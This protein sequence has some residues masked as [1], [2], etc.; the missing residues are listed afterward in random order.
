MASGYI[1]SN[2]DSEIY[3]Y[4]SAQPFTHGGDAGKHLWGKNTGIRV[5]RSRRSH[6]H[7]PFHI[8][9]RDCKT[10][11]KK[12]RLR[13]HG[14]VFV[15]A[16][17]DFRDKA[18]SFTT[19]SMTVPSN[20]PAPTKNTSTVVETSCSYVVFECEARECQ[21][22]H[23]FFSIIISLFLLFPSNYKNIT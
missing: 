14:F 6:L 9:Q 16:P 4:A 10:C 18:P 22:Y 2:D 19:I 20:C 1:Q 7:V 8:P 15:R 17:Y 11:K 21:S 23:L 13:K 12:V 3:L 5:V